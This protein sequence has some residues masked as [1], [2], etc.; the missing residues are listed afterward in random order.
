MGGYKI[1]VDMDQT[2]IDAIPSD[3]DRYIHS[4]GEIINYSLYQIGNLGE[5]KSS[6]HK[7]K[8]SIRPHAIEMVRSIIDNNHVYIIWSAGMYEYV[9]AIMKYFTTISLIEPTYIYTR[10]DMITIDGVGYKSMMSKGYDIDDILIIDDN[11]KFIHPDERHRIID[12]S[13]WYTANYADKELK[14]V[15]Q[16]LYLYDDQV[17]QSPM[18]R[19]FDLGPIRYSPPLSF[20]QNINGN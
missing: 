5:V 7:V 4:D 19:S 14:L 9:H 12:V 17:V 1:M 2:L 15:M 3:D 6:A 10:K 13:P 16:I 11:R 8:V 18:T 20:I